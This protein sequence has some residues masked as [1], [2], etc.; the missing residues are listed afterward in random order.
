MSETWNRIFALVAR[1]EIRI[2]DH[3]YDELAEENIFARDIVDGVMLIV[4]SRNGVP[5][6]LTAERWQHI[7]H[8]H[9]EM[10]EQRE[11]VLETLAEPELIQ[12]GDYGEL[13]ALRLYTETPRTTK[14]LVVVYREIEQRDGFIVTAYF[15]IRP[16]SKRVILWKL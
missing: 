13:L 12:E 3:G 4:Y 14:Y 8:R 15:T 16:S 7:T 11:R 2:S 6:R 1:G 5:V 10:V 9:P